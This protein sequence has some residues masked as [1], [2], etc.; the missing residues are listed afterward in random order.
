MCVCVL[1]DDDENILV[2]NRFTAFPLLFLL[3][4]DGCAGGR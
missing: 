4:S 2:L 3:C 1:D